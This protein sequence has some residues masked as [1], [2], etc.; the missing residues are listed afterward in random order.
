[1]STDRNIES[2]Q[3]EDHEVRFVGTADEP[4]WVAADVCT[5]LELDTSLAVNGR[6][7][8]PGSGLDNDEKG[9]AIVSTPGGNQE[10]LTI[11]EPGLYKLI[12]S[13]RKPQAKRF[14]RWVFH[15]VLPSIR[16][17]GTYSVQQQ[18]DH[19]Q[20]LPL[21]VRRERLEIIQIGIKILSQVGGIDERTELSLNDL[22]KNILLEDHLKKPAL[23]EVQ[24]QGE[25]YLW[26]VSDR[27]SVLGCHPNGGKL[28]AI[29]KMAAGL[30]RARYGVNPPKRE[31]FVDGATRMVNCYGEED[32]EIL[33]SAIQAVMGLPKQKSPQLSSDTPPSIGFDEI[34][35]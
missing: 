25:R 6:P 32:L 23:P 16:R 3:F 34:P 18:T 27:S 7:D 10:M 12:T 20:L 19:P 13:S 14:Q 5:I 1:M 9:T 21:R 8:R 33:D 24:S 15:D 31:Q 22:V 17:T 35:F 4:E 26:P 2:F 11:N 28:K 29:G 30:Y